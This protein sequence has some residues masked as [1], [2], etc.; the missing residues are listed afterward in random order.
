MLWSPLAHET[1]ILENLSFGKSHLH[2]IKI[3]FI[4]GV[5]KSSMPINIQLT[6]NKLKPHEY[7]L[8]HHHH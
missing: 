1:L 4:F 7:N 6:A 8:Y 3:T 5:T 2:H